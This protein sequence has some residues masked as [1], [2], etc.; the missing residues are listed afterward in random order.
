MYIML[1]PIHSLRPTVHIYCWFL[2]LLFQ[3]YSRLANPKKLIFQNFWNKIF[4]YWM[5][6]L[7][8]PSCRITNS[9]IALTYIYNCTYVIYL[10]YNIGLCWT[11][12]ENL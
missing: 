5:P 11:M 10:L 2:C 8:C 12:T 9:V 3:N 1:V 4:T 6:F 7:G